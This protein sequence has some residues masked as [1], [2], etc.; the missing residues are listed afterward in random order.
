VGIGCNTDGNDGD[1]IVKKESSYLPWAKNYIVE[2]SCSGVE[3]FHITIRDM[4]KHPEIYEII[5]I[6]QQ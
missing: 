4:N 1:G 2:G 3:F 5:K 6:K